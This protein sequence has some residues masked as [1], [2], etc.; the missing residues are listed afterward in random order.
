MVSVS[1][2]QNMTM[3]EYAQFRKQW[4]H[5]P[6]ERG[7]FRDESPMLGYQ[8]TYKDFWDDSKG[9]A[10]YLERWVH[11]GDIEDLEAMLSYVRRD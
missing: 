7:I 8:E 10:H 5:R 6:V 1:D 4:A 2:I 9:Y 3:T 11:S